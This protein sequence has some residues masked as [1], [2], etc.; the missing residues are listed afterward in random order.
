V[1]IA[2]GFILVDGTHVLASARKLAALSVETLCV[3]HGPPILTQTS[4]RIREVVG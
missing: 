3:G 4:E 1:R 2:P